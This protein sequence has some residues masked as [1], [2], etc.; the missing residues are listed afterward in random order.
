MLLVGLMW[1]TM[2]CLIGGWSGGVGEF[3]VD[4]SYM[5]EKLK[6]LFV[7]NFN[8]L[9]VLTFIIC[10][11]VI[12]LRHK[13][14]K[15]L[16]E[17][18][19]PIMFSLIMYTIFSAMFKT[20]NHARY[21][22]AIPVILYLL[23]FWVVVNVWRKRAVYYFG[24]ASVFMLLS[25]FI[26]IDPVSL[27]SFSRMNTGSMTMIT[28]GSPSM[29]DA[30]IYNKQM[31]RQEDVFNQALEYAINKEYCIYIPMFSGVAYS[32]DGLMVNGIEQNGQTVVTQFWDE[33]RARRTAYE[34][35]STMPF[36]V[37]EVADEVTAYNDVDMDKKGCYIYSD[38]LGSEL[39]E[40]LKEQNPAIILKEFHKS[41]WTLYMLEF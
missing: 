14:A 22:A 7:L 28:T 36:Y 6:V 10:L 23:V 11:G 19:I 40:Q 38:I 31:L 4:F 17:R 30:M 32:F 1:V 16:W 12:L 9:M 27:L 41:G 26:T 15:G 33:E 20:V 37:Y 39:A 8:W 2:Y 3:S 35:E 21:A 13:E 25:S 18:C 34:G 29:G 5:I 24:I